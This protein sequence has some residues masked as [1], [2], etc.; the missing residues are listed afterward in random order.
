MAKVMAVAIVAVAPGLGLAEV[1][2][3]DEVDELSEVS[4]SEEA[5]A[6]PPRAAALPELRVIGSK[7]AERSLPGSGTFVSQEEIRQKNDEDVH[8]ILR[9]V[10]GVAVR[11]EDGHG[12]FPHISLRGTDLN[13]SMKL[14]MME[15]GVLVAPAPYTA[16]G[17]YFSPA[18]GRMSGLEVLKG[19]SQVKYGPHTIGGV[20]NYLSTPIPEERSFYSKTLVGSFGDLIQHSHMGNTLETSQGG[21]WGYLLEW[22]S[23]SSEG[24]KP[25]DPAP[26]DSLAGPVREGGSNS[27]RRIEP[28]LK[29][30][31][32][33]AGMPGHRLEFK[34]GYSQ[35]FADESYLGLAEEDFQ[36]S[37]YRRYSGTRFDRLNFEQSRS[38]LR[39]FYDNGLGFNWIVTA[40]YNQFHR[41]WY[42]LDRVGPN[43]GSL[44]GLGTALADPSRVAILRGEAPGAFL[45]KANNRDYYS[46]GLDQLAR[47]EWAGSNLDHELEVGLRYHSDVMKRLQ[48]N[49]S[50]EQG[51]TGLITNVTYGEPGS[52]DFDRNEARAVAFFV[53]DRMSYGNWSWTPGVRVEHVRLL[54]KNFKPG[55]EQ[56]LEGDLTE[57]APGLGMTYEVSPEWMLFGGVYRGLSIPSPSAVL[58]DDIKSESSLNLELGTRFQPSEFWATEATVFQARFRD[59]Y[60]PQ[61]FAAGTTQADSGGDVNSW[62]VE[63]KTQYDVGRAQDWA[64][65]NP[66]YVVA[67]YTEARLKGDAQSAN[68]GSVFYGGSDGQRLPYIPPLQ[69]TLGTELSRPRWALSLAASYVDKTWSTASN[70]DET[71]N[72][73]RIGAIDSYV[74]V[75]MGGRYNL[76]PEVA[77]RA[78]VHNLF[79]QE[80]MVARHPHGPRPGKPFSALVGLE[81]NF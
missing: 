48:H 76:S 20:L 3:V 2:E 74:V 81:A 59:L 61:S 5:K 53:Q 36:A 78:S 67:T 40:Y 45:V 35:G 19:S 43:L 42:K 7:E 38:F 30:S 10:P 47:W 4:E 8:R 26:G 72:D 9:R 1:N 50:F 33:P 25:I 18:V 80:Y 39:H 28:M 54:H 63:F 62:G 11:D 60:V 56:D 12:L 75:D 32:E 15:D 23:R 41:N 73:S 58:K 69:V 13:R 37:P 64:I 52:A 71:A 68:P 77:L 6:A 17:A 66:W 24:F 49:D 16:P 29:L 44:G 34:Y 70:Q 65:S 57:V 31:Y 55:S 27:M 51:A 22:Y 79:D 46:W 21:R 14:T